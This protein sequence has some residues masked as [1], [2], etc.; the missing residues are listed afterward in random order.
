MELNQVIGQADIAFSKSNVRIFAA[1]RRI[2]IETSFPIFH[3][4][5]KLW[6]LSWILGGVARAGVH[7][8]F[9]IMVFSGYMPRSGVVGLHDNSIFQVLRNLHPV[10]HSACTNLHSWHILKIGA[11]GSSLG[12]LSFAD[13]IFLARSVPEASLCLPSSLKPEDVLP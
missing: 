11:E 3:S 9:W 4:K 5:I 8:S 6:A 13:N 7:V 10:F 1:W 2:T 12:G